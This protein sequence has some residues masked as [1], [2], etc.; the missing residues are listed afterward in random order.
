[1]QAEHKIRTLAHQLAQILLV[2]AESF[3]Q[4]QQ[5]PSDLGRY[6]RTHANLDLVRVLTEKAFPGGRGELGELLLCHT[7]LK[8]L[9]LRRHMGRAA[10]ARDEGEGQLHELLDR[11]A[12]LVENLR[13]ICAQRS[14]LA[15]EPAVRTAVPRANAAVPQR[16][17]AAGA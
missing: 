12:R 6:E 8:L 9:V 16:P 10:A 5:D 15:A 4:W 17:P 1:M 14:G 7:E 11:H 2:Y 3:A 13:A